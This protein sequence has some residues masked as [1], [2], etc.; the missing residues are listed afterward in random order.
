MLG[1]S[2]IRTLLNNYLRMKTKIIT[3]FFI[4]FAMLSVGNRVYATTITAVATGNWSATSTWDGAT[5]PTATDSVVVPSA[6]TVT[7]DAANYT[8]HGIYVAG[9]VSMTNTFYVGNI[10]IAST[11]KFYASTGN[12]SSKTLYWGV[13]NTGT[14][15]TPT[16]NHLAGGMKI[17]VDGQFGGTV[18]GTNDGIAINYGELATS[19]TIDGVSTAT[20]FISR[21]IPYGNV[22]QPTST[23]F[24]L[25]IKQNLYISNSGYALSLQN[26]KKFVGSRTMTIFPGYKVTLIANG[27]LH[28]NNSTT[29]TADEG[30]V[31]YNI[32]GTL[33]LATG[34]TT[35]FDLYTTNFA[36]ST[37]TITVNVGNG[38]N[39]G[40]L[41][42]GRNINIK[43]Y[44]EAQAINLN[45]N[46]PNSRI[47]FGGNG[48]IS[49]LSTACS[50]Y[51]NG[52]AYVDD[53]R[54]F[55]SA[56]R[57]LSYEN[58]VTTAAL[59]LPRKVTVTDTL[60]MNGYGHKLLV[61]T[62]ADGTA[63]TVTLGKLFSMNNNAYVVTG[64]SSPLTTVTSTTLG[65]AGTWVKGAT[66][67]DASGNTFYCDSVGLYAGTVVFQSGTAT[68][69]YEELT[70]APV[71]V[72]GNTIN[73]ISNGCT[74]RFSAAA[75]IGGNLTNGAGTL[76]L[77]FPSTVTGTFTNGGTVSLNRD[78]S[79]GSLVNTG[80]FAIN[81]NMLTLTSGNIT[82]SSPITLSPSSGYLQFSGTTEQ[83]LSAGNLS[84][85]MNELRVAA[86]S[87][88]SISGSVTTTTLTLFSTGSGTATILDNGN[89]TV[90]TANIKQY[91]AS[92]RNW[93]ISSPVTGATSSAITTA[94][95][96]SMVS[97]NE[98]DG[99]WPAADATLSAGKGY[100][101]VSPVSSGVIT[102]T[103]TLNTGTQSFSL[104]RSDTAIVKRG[105]NLV[106]NPYPSY[107][108]WESATR[109][110]VGPTMWYRSKDAGSYVFA[111]YGAVSQLG[112]SLGGTPVTK[113]IPPM[114]A[115]WVRVSGAGSGTLAFDNSMR[116]HSATSNLLKAPAATAATQQVLRLLVSN[117]TNSDE[118]IVFF[119]EN[120]SNGFDNYDS[121]KM[122][123]ANAAIPEIYTMA[124]G[125]KLVIN[126][127]TSVTPNEELALGFTT[128]QSNTFSIKATEFS[129]FGADTKVYL[130]DNVLNTEQE[131]TS[132]AE[133]SFSSDIATTST[134]FSVVFKSAGVAT[135]INNADVRNGIYKN[136]NNQIV[137]SCNVIGD[138]ASVSVYNA[139][140]QKLQ[141]KQITGTSTMIGAGLPAGVYM[142]TL[143]NAGKTTT[144]KIIL[145]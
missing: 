115:F 133:Y 46:N 67:T 125:E 18:A 15:A 80:S 127:L 58:L 140:G 132:G 139:V 94:T 97:Y 38:T 42:L 44:Y 99:T 77:A 53:A 59:T 137:I 71:K 82:G 69:G 116:S 93:Y 112:T 135:G 23:D 51:Y 35:Y 101:A 62:T 11:G 95:G 85:A 98:V 29:P 64:V 107:L 31:T 78:L 143:T 7:I 25:N 134:R 89:L 26:N 57:N 21:F 136:A 114:Q 6:Y 88:L 45:W 40:V 129:N 79:V 113:Y 19:L 66:L 65:A 41:K 92:G 103:G 1:V 63:R 126:G 2:S 49:L 122:S 110:N 81:T 141:T 10:N 24:N 61:G 8:C 16:P 13:T 83:T 9:T 12:S 27:R 138:D 43:R 121:P 48:A 130:R 142:V 76:Y 100:I 68:S 145:N 22:E 128:G 14:P 32:Y 73:N 84:G 96:N 34:N 33:D 30:N 144:S 39:Y 3:T 111:T 102:F 124:G 52:S 123:N 50:G 28:T 55:P 4:L 72:T 105:F 74:G 118:A 86:G 54:I 36:G 60:Y 120:A 87:K 47:V 108:N 91:L 20:N 119:N 70:G 106:G 37:Q 5:V 131:L 109:T 117:G 75:Y 17:T 56:I 90:T 104:N